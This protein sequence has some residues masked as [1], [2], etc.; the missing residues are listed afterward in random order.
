[1]MGEQEEAAERAGRAARDIEEAI[2]N[3]LGT[4]Y[5]DDNAKYRPKIITISL[6]ELR[7]RGGMDV[8]DITVKLG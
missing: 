5:K 2:R 4:R 1:M 3:V 6:G 7:H 8:L